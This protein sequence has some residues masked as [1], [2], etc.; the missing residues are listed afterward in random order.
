MLYTLAQVMQANKDAGQNFFSPGAMRFFNSRGSDCVY[1]VEN[2]ALFVTSERF[3]DT[4]PYL[5]TV[6]RIVNGMVE[7]VSEFQEYPSLSDAHDRARSEALKLNT[8]D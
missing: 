6:R 5:Y 2:G 4:Y 1:P 3:D 7:D 8:T